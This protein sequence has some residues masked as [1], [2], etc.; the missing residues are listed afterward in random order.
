[1]GGDAARVRLG[2]A[3]DVVEDAAI[4]LSTGGI[5]VSMRGAKTSPGSDRVP[6]LTLRHMTPGR[7]V[8]SLALLVGR[9]PSSS[10]KVHGARSNFSRL[11]QVL[12]VF[13][14]P[15]APRSQSWASTGSRTST[16][17]A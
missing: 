7:R 6:K 10:T 12:P 15:H 5:T 8:R 4:L 2:G 3:G 14:W 17:A 1:M 13:A 9:A 11:L 16:L